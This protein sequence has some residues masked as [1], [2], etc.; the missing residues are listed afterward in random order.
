MSGKKTGRVLTVKGGNAWHRCGENVALTERMVT[1]GET[2]DCD[3]RY[4]AG[5]YLPEHYATIIHDE[6]SDDWRIVKRS[7]FVDISIDGKGCVD[8]VATLS[9]GD[10]I[11]IEG[12]QMALQFHTVKS[13]EGTKEQTWLWLIAG[14]FGVLS[15]VTFLLGT[16]QRR[17]ISEQDVE[18][19]ETSLFIVKVDSVQ[20]IMISDGQEHM[21]HP[22]KNLVNHAPT[23][24]AF[25]T[26][27]GL[28]VTA[29]HCVEYWIG[30]DL[31]LK[32]KVQDMSDD[33]IVRWAIETETFNQQHQ[34]SADSVM[35]MRSYFSIY[36][37]HGN[38]KHSL[39]STDP[40]VHINKSRD[41]V[42]LMGDFSG[43]YYWRSIRPYFANNE[44]MLGDILWIDGLTER[45]QVNL[46]NQDDVKGMKRGTP[47]MICGYPNTGMGDKR[48][49]FAPGTIMREIALGKENLFFDSNINHG[50]SGGPVLMKT[51]GRVV[52]VGV[53]SCVDSISSGLYKWAVPVT[54]IN[55]NREGQDD[56]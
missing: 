10:V 8:Y 37:Y 43:E 30:S 41:G 18:A 51:H 17:A 29:R 31:D 27:D 7:Q 32:T 55:N 36:D 38:Q 15:V 16:N 50:F 20:H 46:A 42:F 54:E 23:G 39:S 5:E 11:R 56:E 28:L 1:I 53:V 47:L 9:D 22:T 4:D 34:D 52:A 12:H 49:T 14:I 6:G 21:Q 3:V 13:T 35:L 25:L 45:G 2:C 24:T 33:D 40:S 19:L 44:M 26:S 48:V